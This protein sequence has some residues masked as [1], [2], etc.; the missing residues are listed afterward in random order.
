MSP[1]L[2]SLVSGEAGL[3][4]DENAQRLLSIFMEAG[5]SC[6]AQLKSVVDAQLRARGK[7]E[8]LFNK[9]YTNGLTSISQ[10]PTTML[11]GEIADIEAHYPELQK[12]HQFVLLSVLSESPLAPSSMESLSIPPVADAYHGFLKRLV[13][14]A[15][16]QRGG[17]F[18]D[19]P[20]IYRKVVFVQAFRNAY[21]DLAQ[22]YHSA[23]PQLKPGSFTSKL[24]ASKKDQEEDQGSVAH[25]QSTA[26]EEVASE[27]KHKSRLHKAIAAASEGSF[28]ATPRPN[29]DKSVLLLNSPASLLHEELEDASKDAAISP[30]T[31]ALQE[32]IR[33]VQQCK[34]GKQSEES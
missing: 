8:A 4:A 17:A 26:G 19:L 7:D 11:R 6:L 31:S 27:R 18:L 28:G 24:A 25:S 30:K 32:G 3:L 5:M 9:Y 2:T 33:T 29:G 14:E 1:L 13:C 16:V 23:L 15:D 34:E 10:W 22:K 20:L 12:L 21:H